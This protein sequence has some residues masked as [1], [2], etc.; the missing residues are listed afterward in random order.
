MSSPTVNPSDII[1]SFHKRVSSEHN[2]IN[3][4]LKHAITVHS[5]RDAPHAAANATATAGNSFRV[6]IHGENDDEL[7]LNKPCEFV[8]TLSES[9][10]SDPPT[11]T[12]L[13][14][15]AFIRTLHED[16]RLGMQGSIVIG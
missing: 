5:D 8:I 16:K 13:D 12:I 1:S 7:W 4:V 6:T 10:P 11:L 3:T 15:P 14:T 2:K 9:F